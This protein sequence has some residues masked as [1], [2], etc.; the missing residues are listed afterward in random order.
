MA[1]RYKSRP[2]K[3]AIALVVAVVA[4]LSF[5][6]CSPYCPGKKNMLFPALAVNPPYG[7]FPIT[8]E[9]GIYVQLSREKLPPADAKKAQLY[10]DGKPQPFDTLIKAEAGKQHWISFS[11]IPGYRRVPKMPVTVSE[12]RMTTA[13]ATYIPTGPNFP[14]SAK[15]GGTSRRARMMSARPM[16]LLD[17]NEGTCAISYDYNASNYANGAVDVV[18]SSSDHPAGTTHWWLIPGGPWYS[19]L[20]SQ[21]SG[22][23]QNVAPGTPYVYFEGVPGWHPPHFPYNY[24]QIFVARHN[25]TTVW[26][27][28]WH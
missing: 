7:K 2:M 22:I 20:T 15:N 23:Q 18:W 24:W 5:G 16:G 25:K 12:G 26:L 3:T 27:W 17:V 9:T 13:I 11:T 4:S 19:I 10:V 1:G 14:A 21:G 28:Y 8:K 6:G